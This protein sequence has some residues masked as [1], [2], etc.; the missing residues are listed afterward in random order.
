M[1]EEGLI[2]FLADLAKK[3]EVPNPNVPLMVPVAGRLEQWEEGASPPKDP[4][5][6][7][8]VAGENEATGET[9]Q[10][11]EGVVIQTRRVESGG[12][13]ASGSDISRESEEDGEVLQI[14]S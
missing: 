5:D 3:T 6:L 14:D 9:E 10:R 4:E 13:C 2:A 1:D 12:E 11:E 7:W 8:R